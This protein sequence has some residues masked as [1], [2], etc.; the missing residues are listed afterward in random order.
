MRGEIGVSMDVGI[1][2]PDPDSPFLISVVAGMKGILASGRIGIRLN[3]FLVAEKYE[4]DLYYIFNA[5][6]FEFYV[7]FEIAFRIWRISYSYQY[8]L[9]RQN[10]YLFA[11]EKHKKKLHDMK[12]LNLKAKILLQNKIKDI[13]YL[14]K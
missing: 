5:F 9:I 14:L 1:Y 13:D 10:Y 6:G 3:L 7:K 11:V 2:I 12:F 8:Y 4:T